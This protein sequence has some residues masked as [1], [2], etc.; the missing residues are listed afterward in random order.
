VQPSPAGKVRPTDKASAKRFSTPAFKA[1]VGRDSETKIVR[2]QAEEEELEQRPKQIQTESAQGRGKR[3]CTR[4][5]KIAWTDNT[6]AVTSRIVTND[7]QYEPDVSTSRQSQ[8]RSLLINCS[9]QVLRKTVNR[10]SEAYPLLPSGVN[11][12]QIKVK[13]YNTT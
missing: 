3:S 4:D 5:I 9:R 11:Y 10:P 1:N 12:T 7:S 2:E 6:G 8:P 13:C